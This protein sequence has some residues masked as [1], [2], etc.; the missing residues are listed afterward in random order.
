[1]ITLNTK[2]TKKELKRLRKVVNKATDAG[3]KAV[4]KPSAEILKRATPVETAILQQGVGVRNLQ[5]REKSRYGIDKQTRAVKI[6]FVRK[7]KGAKLR[8]IE[9]K[10]TLPALASILSY[11]AKRHEIKAKSKKTLKFG[12]TYSKSVI[13]P[14]VKGSGFLTRAFAKMDNSSLDLF[15]KGVDKYMKKH[16]A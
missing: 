13:H 11:G 14:G 7:T 10:I 15:Y 9:K 3:L 4:A 8:Q 2:A 5:Q 1:M 16:G 12:S 6:G